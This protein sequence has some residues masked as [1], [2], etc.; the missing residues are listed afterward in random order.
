[1]QYAPRVCTLVLFIL[2]SGYTKP[3]IQASLEDVPNIVQTI[4]LHRVILRSLA[5]LSQFQ[6][7]DGTDTLGVGRAMSLYPE[8][9]YE[10]FVNSKTQKATLTAG[11]LYSCA[12]CSLTDSLVNR[13]DPQVI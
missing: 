9:L 1:M 7:R 6:F 3:L 13:K 2:D 5:E 4:T 11:I 10:F 12:L 8:L